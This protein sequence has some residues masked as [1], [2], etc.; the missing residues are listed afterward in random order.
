MTRKIMYAVTLASL[1]LLLGNWG[2]T[3]NAEAD[4]I[5]RWI[6]DAAS[7][8]E[9]ERLQA[10]EALGK[11]GDLRAL[12]PLLQALHD[13]NPTIR[14]RA[15]AALHTLRRTLSDLY[16]KIAQWI[17]ELLITWGAYTSPAPPVE[18]TRHLRRI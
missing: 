15:T 4:D 16:Y 17:E 9:P 11:S 8:S 12:Q 2:G 5:E 18:S 6:R 14:E 13:A 10:L 3:R 1:L 7:A